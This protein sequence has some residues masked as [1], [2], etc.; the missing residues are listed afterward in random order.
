MTDIEFVILDELYFM[1]D[2]DSIH[3]STKLEENILENCLENLV[4]KEWIAIFKNDNSAE[5]IY[6]N[7]TFQDNF[8]SYYYLAT[9]KGLFEHNSN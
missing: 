7:V 4:K 8:K 9:K 1:V 3:K 2:Y 5:L 6:D